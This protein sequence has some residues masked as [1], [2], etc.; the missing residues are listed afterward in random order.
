MSS[1]YG[2][3]GSRV[4]ESVTFTKNG[5]TFVLDNGTQV[6]YNHP[7]K[8]QSI[9]DNFGIIYLDRL[10]NLWSVLSEKIKL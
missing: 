4:V 5:A 6:N 9:I 3:L 7:D 2:E 10:D 8:I 1:K